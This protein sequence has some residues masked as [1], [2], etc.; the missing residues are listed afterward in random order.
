VPSD[1]PLPVSFYFRL[2]FSNPK[3]GASD[4]AFQEASGLSVELEIEEVREGGQNMYKHRFP[5]GAKYG[6]LVLKRG[7]VSQGSKLAVWCTATTTTD[8]SRPIETFDV[9]LHLLDASGEAQ[10][11]W[12]FL[13]AYPVKW[14]LSDFRAQENALAIE[15]LELAYSM[16]QR[17]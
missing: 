7:F 4:N 5:T 15:T 11:T 10:A 13:D 12:A 9:L 17:E 3:F 14:S 16:F 1:Y 8:F 2:Q 6:N